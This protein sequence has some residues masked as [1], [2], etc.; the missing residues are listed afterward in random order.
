MLVV[1]C[2]TKQEQPCLWL[3]AQLQ[4]FLVD[5]REIK[6]DDDDDDEDEADEVDEADAAT[7]T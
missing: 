2:C 4:F 6:E 5:Y 1:L 7:A 3:R